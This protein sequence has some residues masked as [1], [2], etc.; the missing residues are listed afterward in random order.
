MVQKNSVSTSTQ[1]SKREKKRRRVLNGLKKIRKAKFRDIDGKKDVA[2]NHDQYLD[3]I[4][5]STTV[6]II[7]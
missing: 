4:Y 5:A 3:E 1:N 6:I 2:I 7:P